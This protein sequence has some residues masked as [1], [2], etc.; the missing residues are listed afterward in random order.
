[1]LLC[2][3]TL[4]SSS[5]QEVWCLLEEKAHVWEWQ[6]FFGKKNAD[7]ISLSGSFSWNV[8]ETTD[9]KQVKPGKVEM[10]LTFIQKWR[11]QSYSLN[12]KSD[13]EALGW[14]TLCQV[15]EWNSASGHL[16]LFQEKEQHLNILRMLSSLPCH[17]LSRPEAA[18]NEIS[19]H[20]RERK[21]KEL[22]SRYSRK[23][24]KLPVLYQ[25]KKDCLVR[26]TQ[27]WIR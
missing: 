2:K 14:D 21:N 25:I 5:L 13:A 10:M 20:L 7:W 22:L 16:T 19:P 9:K 24:I 4:T 8:M 1:M 27:P 11:L 3:T 12:C 23:K 18:E 26:T 17:F 6:L 15:R